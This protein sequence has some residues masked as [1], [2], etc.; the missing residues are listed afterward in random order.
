GADEFGASLAAAGTRLLVGAPQDASQ[1]TAS[2]SVF[3]YDVNASGSSA[4]LLKSMKS[5]NGGS[6]QFGRSPAAAG[7]RALVGADIDDVTATD[8]GAAFLVDIDPGSATFGTS[9]QTFKKQTPATGDRF[10]AA[11]AFLGD[12]VLIAA[13]Q[14]DAGAGD[15]GALYRFN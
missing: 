6:T 8:S 15:A 11:V 1:A 3:V 10:G 5:P 14:D 4:T 7:N 13:T 12:D 9:L 2:G